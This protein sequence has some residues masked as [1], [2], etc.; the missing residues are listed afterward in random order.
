M[1]QKNNQEAQT[2]SRKTKQ[3]VD[4]DPHTC[5]QEIIRLHESNVMC[6]S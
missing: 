3:L 5:I 4:S 6:L 2:R 1:P